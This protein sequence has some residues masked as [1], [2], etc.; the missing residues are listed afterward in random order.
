[1]LALLL[2]F[3]LHPRGGRSDGA[4]DDCIYEN[5]I[6]AVVARNG[7]HRDEGATNDHGTVG[8]HAQLEDVVL[9]VPIARSA[10]GARAALPLLGEESED[11]LRINGLQVF[12]PVLELT[13]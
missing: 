2:M 3:C 8:E 12:V 11:L 1:M 13:M 6:A 9:H 7:Y 5:R 10:H 4:G